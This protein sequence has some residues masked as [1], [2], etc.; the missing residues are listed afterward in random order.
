MA[1]LANSRFGYWVLY[2]VVTSRNKYGVVVGEPILKHSQ[3]TLS[4][5]K[6]NIYITTPFPSPSSLNVWL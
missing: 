6:S 4:T 2:S 3:K 5:L 1:D